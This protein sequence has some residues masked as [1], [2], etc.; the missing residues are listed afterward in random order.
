MEEIFISYKSERRR[1]AEH[2]AEVLRR[3]G[4]T[5]WFDYYLIKGEDFD[6]QLDAKLIAAKA[7]VVLW[8]T[9]SVESKWVSREATKAASR[10][11]LVPL[12]IEDC[13]MKT[14]HINADC[15][16]LRDWDGAPR[17]R[18]LDAL[19]D[20]VEAKVGRAPVQDVKALRAY[21]ATWERFGAPSLRKFALDGPGET[22]EARVAAS[23]AATAKGG[24][25]AD[26][27]D[28]AALAAEAAVVWPDVRD[29]GD[30]KRLA[31]FIAKFAGTIYAEEAVD[32]RASIEREAAGKPA[33]PA[34]SRAGES[35]S[36]ENRHQFLVR[37]LEGHASWVKRVAITPDGRLAISVSADDT[38]KVWEIATGRERRTPLMTTRSNFVA[39]TPDG[40]AAICQAVD[41][42]L[43]E[44]DIAS[45][46]EKRS[47]STGSSL[48]LDLA[49][50]TDGHFAVS[51]G[52]AGDLSVWELRA[53]KI[54]KKLA[55]H[56][57][58]KDVCAVALTP[59]DRVAIS[60]SEDKTLKVWDLE[61]GAALRT[62]SGH[63]QSVKAVAIAPDGRVAISCGKDKTLKIWDITSGTSL[64]TMKG[65]TDWVLAVAISPDGH[66]VISGSMDGT[67]KVWDIA[68]GQELQTLKG[69]SGSVMTVAITPDGRFA[70]SGSCDTTLKVWDIGGI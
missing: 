7:V 38:L 68:S 8:C 17:S 48:F 13:E 70:V 1:A 29:S 31:R 20:A 28:R 69:H 2:L 45:E 46:T 47:L 51:G 58:Y 57:N 12:K 36:D 49:L 4:Y 23:G 64:R 18:Q 22:T 53:W 32:L 34:A 63:S 27:P 5:V 10:G 24:P 6:F 9:K 66:R 26:G 16:S 42:T 59:D 41:F 56:S 11:T 33:N 60:A 54:I 35:A 19:L 44:W 61:S 37:T 40:R 67:L 65:H 52:V 55:G 15:L 21:E 62:L 50:S 39:I 43:R 3:H 14:A 30:P 25:Q